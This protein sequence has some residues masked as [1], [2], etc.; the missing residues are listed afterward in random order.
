MRGV[1]SDLNLIP[2]GCLMIGLIAESKW[3]ECLGQVGTLSPN[4]PCEISRSPL[5]ARSAIAGKQAAQKPR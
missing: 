1:S 2:K 3:S 4:S 5:S